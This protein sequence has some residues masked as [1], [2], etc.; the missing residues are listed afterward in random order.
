MEGLVLTCTKYN[1][2]LKDLGY[3]VL[4]NFFSLEKEKPKFITEKYF[5]SSKDRLKRFFDGYLKSG[6]ADAQASY[7]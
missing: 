5:D 3:T 7:W 2:R 6:R 1:D 4:E